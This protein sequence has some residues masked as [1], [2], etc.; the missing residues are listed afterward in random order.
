[1]AS[2]LAS[3]K[4]RISP[5]SGDPDFFLWL[6]GRLGSPNFHQ[7]SFNSINMPIPSREFIPYDGIEVAFFNLYPLRQKLQTW[8][9]RHSLYFLG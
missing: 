6:S 5:F 4:V 7:E 3:S 9:N 2:K 1:L 8:T